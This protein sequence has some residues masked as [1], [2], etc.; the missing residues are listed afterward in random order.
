MSILL[1]TTKQIAPQCDFIPSTLIPARPSNEFIHGEVQPADLS[2]LKVWDSY[3]GA[4]LIESNY[5]PGP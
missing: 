2:G 5:P 3:G 1:N 4:L